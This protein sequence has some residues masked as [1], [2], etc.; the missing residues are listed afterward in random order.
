MFEVG[1]EVEFVNTDLALS[2]WSPSEIPS[3][4]TR[5][6][7]AH[8]TIVNGENLIIV[9]TGPQI[10]WRASRFKMVEQEPEKPVT[11]WWEN[12]L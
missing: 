9:N 10:W 5:A 3:V 6:L 2:L 11:P 4:G 12:N 7:V 8:S 1:D